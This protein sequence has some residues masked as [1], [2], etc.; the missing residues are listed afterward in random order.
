MCR[1]P[2]QGGRFVRPALTGAGLRLPPLAGVGLVPMCFALSTHISQ[3]HDG[4]CVVK[5]C[6]VSHAHCG[7]C[8]MRGCGRVRSDC[9]GGGGMAVVG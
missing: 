9:D 6:C 4:H 7:A 2:Q 8:A 1:P 5:R 3:G